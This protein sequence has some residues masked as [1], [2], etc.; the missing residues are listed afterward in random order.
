MLNNSG[1]KLNP[2]LHFNTEL[3]ANSYYLLE[4]TSSPLTW[5]SLAISKPGLSGHH[6]WEF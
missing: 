1:D 5:F 3:T 6:S 4:E 2:V